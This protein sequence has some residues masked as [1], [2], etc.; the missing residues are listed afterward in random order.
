MGEAYA[1]KGDIVKS[2]QC[3]ES[4]AKIFPEYEIPYQRT[5]ALLHQLGHQ[6]ESADLNAKAQKLIL[7]LI[8]NN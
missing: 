6:Q 7:P 8:I 1:H 3:F 4:A 2:M 5:A